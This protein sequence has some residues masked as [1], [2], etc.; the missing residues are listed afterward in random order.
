MRSAPALAASS[1][2]FLCSRAT[3]WRR[4]P[5]PVVLRSG[6][7]VLAMVLLCLSQQLGQRLDVQAEPS[8]GKPCLD[9]LEQPEVA[10]RITE[11]RP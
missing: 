11:R 9:L 6:R 8:A 10:V 3:M 5:R 7:F 1:G 2:V 4:P